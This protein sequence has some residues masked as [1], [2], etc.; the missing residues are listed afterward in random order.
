MNI[1]CL[2]W[3]SL[4]W[5]Q[6]A[7]PVSGSWQSD[8]PFLPIEFARESADRRITL[9]ITPGAPLVRTLW[10]PLA[11]DTLS[12][13][14]AALA[15][16]EGISEA[17]IKR[18]IGIFSVG[19]DH[20]TLDGVSKWAEEKGSVHVVWTA[21]RPKMGTVFR[22]PSV[23]EVLVHLQG[24]TGND[25]I[26]AEEYVRMAPRQIGTPYRTEIE[27]TLGWTPQGLI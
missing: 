11:V 12:E 2:G 7:L 15:V 10:A 4:I 23:A 17:N 9:V 3:G 21:L 25:R 6:K 5:C 27:E 13:A 19:E 16:R 22:T 1:I 14:I 20:G 24:L 18:S 26:R 8:G